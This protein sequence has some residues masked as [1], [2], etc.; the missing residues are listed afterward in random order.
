M[1]AGGVTT[2]ITFPTG[3]LTLAPG[4]AP[5]TSYDGT[6]WSTT[7]PVA[8]G[9]TSHSTLSFLSAST[10]QLPANTAVRHDLKTLSP[11]TLNLVTILHSF[12]A[13]GFLTACPIQLPADMACMAYPCYGLCV[14]HLLRSSWWSK[15]QRRQTIVDSYQDLPPKRGHQT[16]R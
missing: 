3:T 2:P 1:H 9:S 14:P 7:L 5:A 15:R 12:S 13:L 4:A 8:A 6:A 16:L 11:E 10:T